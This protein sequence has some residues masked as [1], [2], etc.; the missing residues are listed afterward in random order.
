LQKNAYFCCILGLELLATFPVFLTVLKE[1][2]DQELFATLNSPATQGCSWELICCDSGTGR[3][4]IRVFLL[5]AK[6]IQDCSF[7]FIWNLD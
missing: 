4:C 3:Y 1:V 6:S 7:L 5:L 2:T